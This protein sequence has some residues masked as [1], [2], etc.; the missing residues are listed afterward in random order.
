[1]LRSGIEEGIFPR[2]LFRKAGDLGLFGIRIDPKWGGSG[3]DWWA[4]RRISRVHGVL[5]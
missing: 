3:G 2:E 4:E 1:M 5:R